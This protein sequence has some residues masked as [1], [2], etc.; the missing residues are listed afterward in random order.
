MHA[1]LAS[2]VS[3]WVAAL[4]GVALLATAFK[5]WLDSREAE[6]VE[7]AGNEATARAYIERDEFEATLD[8][9]LVEVTAKSEARY[10]QAAERF[11]SFEALMRS[12]WDDDLQNND[13]FARRAT[14]ATGRVFD[15]RERR[16]S[17]IFA[18]GTGLPAATR[19][20]A[21]PD[22]GG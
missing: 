22:A 9:A 8:A 17:E 18:G 3:K 21:E 2:V 12:N 6:A 15:R 14:A 4:I 19:T 11:E 20:P 1:F 10:Q 7:N 16:L 13:D 5:L